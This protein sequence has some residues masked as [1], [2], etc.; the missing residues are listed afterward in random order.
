MCYN[1]GMKKDP[2]LKV[3]TNRI[4]AIDAAIRSGKKFTAKDFA[5]EF[6]VDKRTIDRD[7]EYMRDMLNAPIE[8]DRDL[9]SYIYTEENYYI[10]AV[11]MS[12][13]EL[14]SVA[15]FDQLLEQYKNTP[16]EKN[17][18]AIFSKIVSSLPNTVTFDSAFLSGNVTFIPD[19]AA[20]IEPKVFETIFSAL[21]NRMT[22]EFDYRPLQKTTF[23]HRK[24]D[25]YHAVCQKGNWYVIGYCHDKGNVRI[26]SF[27]RIS[28]PKK[29]R[30]RFEIPSTFKPED[31]F[32]KELGIW[33]SDKNVMQVELLVSKEIGTYALDRYWNSTQKTEQL[34]DGSVRVTFQTTQ[35]REVLRWVLGQGSTVRVINPPELVEMVRTE[36][37]AVSKIYEK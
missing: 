11:P 17:L 37:S 4:L 36:I 22:L 20:M 8:F 23:M 10:K 13:G 3:R 5:E 2:Q 32:D 18:R 16:L 24:I 30:A 6:E 33:L 27:S 9:H 1:E 21:Q 15:L 19:Y 31:F 26:F 29:T 34:K 7:I 25:P 35:I 12:E 14:F 28:A